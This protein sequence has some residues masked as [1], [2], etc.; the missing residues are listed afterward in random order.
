MAY[1]YWIH[2][3]NQNIKTDGYVGVTVNI[4]R[5]WNEHKSRTLD[6][7]K[8]VHLRKSIEKYG[9]DLIFEVLFEGSEEGC[10][11]LEEYFRPSIDIGWNI[12]SGGVRPQTSEKQ[13]EAARKANK[14][15]VR[16]QE[17]KEKV[18]K[19]RMGKYSGKD[20]PVAVKVLC[21]TTGD[22]F[23]TVKQGADWCG[24]KN[25]SSIC[26]H[27][28]HGTEFAGKHLET[29]VKLIWKYYKEHNMACKPKKK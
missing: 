23:D 5:R 26:Y 17:E 16:T 8:C 9:S 3:P 21:V 18:S 7:T 2:L 4:K 22:I 11:Q 10:Y 27:I 15:R 25:P 29:K 6:K 24:L 14:G 20:S 13:K 28:K 19:S 1:V 12:V